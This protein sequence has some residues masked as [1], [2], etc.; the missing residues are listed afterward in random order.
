LSFRVTE[1]GST[2]VPNAGH[3]VVFLVIRLVVV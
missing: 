3:V 1:S 2:C